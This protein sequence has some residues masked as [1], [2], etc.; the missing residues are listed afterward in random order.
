MQLKIF[1]T[2]IVFLLVFAMFL[3]LDGYQHEKLNQ[4]CD[5][6]AAR[7]IG[8]ASFVKA[9]SPAARFTG[10]LSGENILPSLRLYEPGY[11]SFEVV[12]TTETEWEARPANYDYYIIPDSMVDKVIFPKCTWEDGG[13]SYLVKINDSTFVILRLPAG[14]VKSNTEFM[15]QY[16]TRGN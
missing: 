7:P 14:R 8:R 13:V 16:F 6:V 10:R 2:A 15:D 3:A 1:M 9:D 4:M 11:K 12:D 5:S